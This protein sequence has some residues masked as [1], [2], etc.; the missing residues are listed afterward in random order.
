MPRRPLAL[1]LMVA[2]IVSLGGVGYAGWRGQAR[3]ELVERARSRLSAG[4]VEAPELHRLQAATAHSL[5]ER[6][7]GLGADAPEV[8][9]L[10]HYAR[11]L[12]YVQSGDLIF[13]KG[14]LDSARQHLGWTPDL[15]VLAGTVA[16]RT[17]ELDQARIHASE[18]LSAEPDHPRALLLEA[19]LALDRRDAEVALRSLERL[20]ELSPDASVVHNRLGLAQELSGDFDAGLASFREAVR[21]NRR[22]H[23]AWINVGRIAAARGDLEG[24]RVAFDQALVY[25]PGE[26]D[27]WLGRGLVMQGLGEVTE[28]DTSLRRA[29]ELA[30]NDAEPLLALGDLF[31]QQ[32]QVPEATELYRAALAIE[33]AD[34]ASWLKLGNILFVAGDLP[35][36]ISA[37]EEA[38]DRAETLSA[39]HNG[40]GAALMRLERLDEAAA[41][42]ERA[43]SLDANDANPLLNLGLLHERAGNQSEARRSWERALE[44]DPS[45]AV[46]YDKLA[47]L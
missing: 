34:A 14:E 36:A 30:P 40:L 45:S 9:G 46:A 33:D 19:D 26:P 11:A 6:A 4:L 21:L 38:I 20:V 25:G 41:A 47:A 42:L 10:A 23:D 31:R 15:H 43:A 39:A 37:Y 2:S 1:V 7:I 8:L 3:D 12:T 32:G 16:R 5:L 24:A 17:T 27:A 35:A 28:A 13:A 29:A 18:A 22:N 44:R